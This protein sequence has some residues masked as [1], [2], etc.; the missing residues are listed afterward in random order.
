MYFSLLIT[1]ALVDVNLVI[2]TLTN[3]QIPVLVPIC[4]HDSITKFSI[5]KY[6]VILY[7]LINFSTLAYMLR[8][9]SR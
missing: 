7:M 6:L 1:N 4:P 9:C 8:T 3:Y 5:C 2:V